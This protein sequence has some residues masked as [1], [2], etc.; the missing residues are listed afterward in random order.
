MLLKV[1]FELDIVILNFFK[2]L[3]SI[4]TTCFRCSTLHLETSFSLKNQSDYRFSGS[5]NDKLKND[6]L[7]DLP[8]LFS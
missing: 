5:T 6:F 2:I 1:L 8:S 7:F 4:K 3:C